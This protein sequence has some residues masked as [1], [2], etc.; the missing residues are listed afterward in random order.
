MIAFH[1]ANP[2]LH[3]L[4]P[5]RAEHR[6]LLYLVLMVMA[7]QRPD[8][9]RYLPS[10][11]LNRLLAEP[12]DAA[13]DA[14]PRAGSM[15]ASF[16]QQLSDGAGR[17]DLSA[18]TFA[19]ILRL[20]GYDLFSHSF[21][22]LT[23]QGDLLH[24]AMQPAPAD[25]DLLPADLVDVQ[26]IG[27]FEKS[28]GLGH[29]TRLCAEVLRQVVLPQPD[30]RSHQKTPPGLRLNCVNFGLDN[31]A[32]EGFSRVGAL[33]DYKPARIN[34]IHL[35]AETVPLAFAYA[36]DVFSRA[37]NIGFVY[38]E[39]DRP[40]DCQHLGIDLL[41]EI[42]VA[43]DYGLTAYQTAMAGKPV[44]NVGMCSEPPATLDKQAARAALNQRLRLRGDEF[45]CLMAF[46]SYSFAQRKN[47]VGAIEAFQRAFPAEG[48]AEAVQARLILKTQNRDHIADPAQNRLWARI[49]AVVARDPRIIVMNEMLDSAALTQL[50][51]AVD[52]YIS[53]HRSEG[54]GFNMIEAMTL[55][56]PVVCTGYS[57]NLEFCTPQTAWLV[58][59]T[60]VPLG[61]DDY[62]YVPEGA[63]WGEP[64]L[65]EAA[66]ALRAIYADPVDRARRTAAALHNI[67]QN[68]STEAIARRYGARL[69]QILPASR[70]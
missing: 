39:L 27:P 49:N 2:Q 48:A 51:A 52:C 54:W 18:Q 4:D 60:E 5:R 32:P 56:V 30:D 53:L 42:W 37:Y 17:A 64:D 63:I 10:V 9:L 23:P 69:R 35:N 21:L 33:A 61:A 62:L 6:Q 55:Q 58:R 25:P 1:S 36:P 28:S 29:S 20:Q 3:F 11:G 12:R 15:L 47:P 66:Q 38:W 16:V 67:Q 57:G 44:V 65:D 24:A 46:D 50:K 7:V 8:L 22:S 34:L 70:G 59:A 41:D 19:A 31:P 26:L 14:T 40:A 13:Q 68:F 45:V 43:S